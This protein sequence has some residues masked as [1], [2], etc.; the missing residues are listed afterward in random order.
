M[1]ELDYEKIGRILGGEVTEIAPTLFGQISEMSPKME[2]AFGKYWKASGEILDGSSDWAT[3]TNRVNREIA[4]GSWNAAIDEAV[5][6]MLDLG[7]IVASEKIEA[8]KVK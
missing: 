3:G 8:L 4:M 5:K 2:A 7:K 1:S 6:V